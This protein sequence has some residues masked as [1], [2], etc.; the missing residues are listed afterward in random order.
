MNFIIFKKIC[1]S[2][3][4]I[5][6]VLLLFS[7]NVLA[8]NTDIWCLYNS[9]EDEI[10]HFFFKTYNNDS[11][12]KIDN[13]FLSLI[14][15]MQGNR[16]EFSVSGDFNNDGYDEIALFYE[17]FYSP[18]LNPEFYA[19]KIMVF[20]SKG[21]KTLPVGSWFSAEQ[22]GFNFSFVKFSV[23]GDFNND[24][25]DDIALFYDDPDSDMEKLI[26]LKSNGRSFLSP[27]VWYSSI[28]NDFDFTRIKYV[29]SGDFNNNSKSDI[30]VFYDFQDEGSTTKQTVFI[31]EAENSKLN[32]LPQNY[33]TTKGDLNFSYLTSVMSGDFDNNKYTDIVAMYSDPDSSKQKILFFAGKSSGINTP[34]K[35]FEIER[36]EFNFKNINFSMPGYYNSDEYEDLAVFIKQQ[37]FIFPYNGN[38][39]DQPEIYYSELVSNFSFDKITCMLSGKFV[40][41]PEINISNWKNN[42]N[43][44]ISFTFDDGAR[45]AFEFGASYLDEKALKGTFY[46]FSDT[47][48][49]YDWPLTSFDVMNTYQD[50]GFE[51]G[52]HT[53]NHAN[54]GL[55]TEQ[56]K[57]AA[58]SYTLSYSK[59]FLDKRMDQN[60][61]TLS[62]P[63]GSFRNETLGYISK[64]FF[65]ARSSQY[66]FNLTT[67][68]DF[69]ALKTYPV[70]AN[71]TPSIVLKKINV[72]EY[73]GYYLPLMFHNITDLEFN[74]DLNE[75]TY[76]YNDF[77]A[78]VDTAMMKDVWIDTHENIYKY[79]RERNSAIISVTH[80]GDNYIMFRVNDGLDNH[81]FDQE[82]TLRLNIPDTWSDNEVNV[83]GNALYEL[84]MVLNDESGKYILFNIIPDNTVYTLSEGTEVGIYSATTNKEFEFTIGPNPFIDETQIL[85]KGDA[86]IDMQIKIADL[87]GRIVYNNDIACN[88][89]LIIKKEVL[90][91]GFYIVQLYYNR[92]ILNSV[93][94][95]AL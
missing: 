56:E 88:I 11:L 62:I 21:N 74:H 51:I 46:V 13:V 54:I 31:F 17:Y 45:G 78:I 36:T 10:D 18:N 95:I 3:Y 92:K 66:G 37:V 15:E 22:S 48:S 57:Y 85:V 80:K 43:G 50:K 41:N 47:N 79:I 5:Y 84:K 12:I 26:V 55:L 91:S 28:R 33:S 81:I 83:S 35:C 53:A 52:S 93:K 6:I 23:S 24:D 75:Y 25:F 59:N 89:P 49:I 86:N 70:L 77:K 34:L 19:S 69:Y 71:T 38:N 64:Y 73:Y 2:N 63:F 58:L 82:L 9:N 32:I 94:L 87:N 20:K 76:A 8:Q 14:Y 7:L 42:K 39:F 65:S 1:I 68:F 61:M 16:P 4:L 44:A 30:A 27:E 29:V 72:S 90:S 40:Y 60:T 67:P